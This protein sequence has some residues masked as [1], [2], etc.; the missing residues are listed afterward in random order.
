MEP[1]LP[2]VSIIMATYNRANLLG[3][4][5]ESVLRQTY[6]NIELI[7]VN[8]GSTD[9]TESVLKSY[10]DSRIKVVIHEFNRG[11]T[12]AKNTGLKHIRG[13]WFTIYDS[14]DEM[15]PD[16]IDTLMN[17]PLKFD[18]EIT[19]I[20]A[21]GWDPI[22]NAFTG[23]GLTEDCYIVASEAMPRCDGDFWGIV[24]SGLLQNEFFNENLI[25]CESTL[26]YSLSERANGYYVHKPLSII[27]TEGNDRITTS[28]V[29]LEKKIRHYESIIDEKLY[30]KITRKFHPDD[31]YDI[32]KNGLLVM[33]LNKNEELASR[34]Y[35]MMKSDHRKFSDYLIYKF[36]ISLVVYRIYSSFMALI[37][38]YSV[39]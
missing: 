11:A 22:S 32:C 34:Y 4:A 33:R 23:K 8:D 13:E 14:D 10:N 30:L 19:A 6:T 20:T 26:W 38:K 21:N 39:V 24:K 7:I 9:D 17:I 15:V 18:P 3:R 25:G 16:A 37:R 1:N 28:K 5:I 2:L 31:Y 35:E 27:H 29:S 36:D 12:A